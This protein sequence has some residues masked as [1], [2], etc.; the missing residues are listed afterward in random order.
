MLPYFL[1]INNNNYVILSKSLKYR[2]IKN[3]V[4]KKHHLIF[5]RVI[6][7]IALIAIGGS[8]TSIL[9]KRDINYC[10]FSNSNFN[11][12]SAVSAILL[13]TTEGTLIL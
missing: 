1:R 5:L 11:V 10:F 4:Y 7:V 3:K 13:L 8:R 2:Q 12:I 6:G 9:K